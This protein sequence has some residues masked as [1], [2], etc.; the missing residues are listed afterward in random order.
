MNNIWNKFSHLGTTTYMPIE[1]SRKV[2]L[3]NQIAY[4]SFCILLLLN[5][6]FLFVD[7][8]E[9]DPVGF[10]TIPLVLSTPLL[11]KL[12]YFKISAFSI[13]TLMPIATLIFSSYS[14]TLMPPP[15][16]LLVY[17][18]PK[19]MLLSFLILP[20][21]LIDSRNKA[22]LFL[23]IAINIA[24]LILVEKVNELMGVGLDFNNVNYENYERLNSLISFP[25]MIIVFGFIF[26]NSI[27][28]KYEDRI[29]TQN[30]NLE[31]AYQKIE[32]INNDLTDSILYA[33]HIQQAIL[34][35]KNIFN[36][37]FAESFIY[38]KPKSMVSG[39]FYFIKEL[40]IKNEKCIAIAVS[41]CTGH[42]V[43][44]GFMSMLGITSLNEIVRENYFTDAADILNQLRDKIKN[45]LN[46]TG[47]ILEQKDGMDM[48]MVLYFPNQKLIEF[49]GARNSI[50]LIGTNNNV[51]IYKGDKMPIGIHVK[52]KPFTN[53]TINIHGNEMCYLFTDGI[54]DQMNEKGEKFMAKNLKSTLVKL[55]DYSCNKQVAL[56]SDKMKNWRT[57]ENNTFEEQVDDMLLLGVRFM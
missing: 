46:Q 45:T 14:K 17:I 38:Y 30:Q 51:A 57:K 21:I 34:P 41:D 27:N 28:R 25:I 36:Q 54:V 48:T 3:A 31:K 37:F 10:F 43:P 1:K 2:I 56:F 53:T 22:L 52:E 16:P 26:L 35:D 55:S 6:S 15:I 44:G 42:G 29:V 7:F 32:R 47:N 39:D 24:C 23:A 18:F 50:Y 40:E 13:S 12:G 11:N 20:L 5:S 33:K 9:F 4:I 49:A 19:L 8:I